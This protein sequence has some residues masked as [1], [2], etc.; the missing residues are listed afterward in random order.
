MTTRARGPIEPFTVRE[1]AVIRAG[2]ASFQFFLM[3]IYPLSFEKRM[4]KMAD[5][6]KHAF[7]LGYIHYLWAKIVEENP[8]A[9]VLAPRMHLKST[10]LNHAFIFWKLFGAN[11]DHDAIVISYKDE[12]ASDHVEKIKKAIDAN[13][14]CRFWKDN[15]P[16]AESIVDY[17]ISF[18]D[19]HTW[20]GKVDAHGIFSTV[21][22]LHPRTVVCDDILSDFANALEPVQIKRI[23]QIFRQSLESLPDE[24]DSLVVIGTSQSYED[25]LFKLKK[26]E[27]YAWFRFPAELPN[28]SVL[29]PEKFDAAR[30][31]RTKRRVGPTAYQVEYLLVP[32]MAVDSFLPIEVVQACLDPRLRQFELDAEFDSAGIAGVYGGMD[33]GK[34]VHPSH[35]SIGALMPTGD[36]I[37]IY[38]QFLDGMD[39]RSQARHVKHI[40]DH[41]GVKRFYYDSTRSEMD[42]R[43]MT[44]RA[45][46][47]RFSARSKA[48][49]AL[50][51]ES[52]FFAGDDEPG[53][54]LLDDKRQTGQIVA[55]NRVLKSIEN[56]EGHGDSMWSIAL[57]IKAADD[58][59]MIQLLGNVQDMFNR[60]SQRHSGLLNLMRAR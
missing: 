26:N 52:R 4:W 34:N 50:S 53:I 46:G 31:A 36:I 28:G 57:M 18:D 49:M 42:D 9:C 19:G 43:D 15:K 35:I 22:G 8:R 13:A 59:P 10:V 54:I 39:Y 11:E 2:Q 14:F 45:L 58:G 1:R 38:Q 24:A 3:H 30:L 48:Q 20:N 6:Q 40:I 27:Q 55:V 5:G 44:R 47:I 60:Q 41:F 21:R 51:M 7:S 32:F 12:L 37:Q 17:D 16:L 29:W 56:A 25:T 23:D 33:I